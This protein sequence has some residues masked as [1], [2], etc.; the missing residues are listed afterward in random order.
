ME[1]RSKERSTKNKRPSS[2]MGENPESKLRQIGGLINNMHLS[3]A[4][5]ANLFHQNLLKSG[6]LNKSQSHNLR[7]K[8]NSSKVSSKSPCV[9]NLTNQITM[10]ENILDFNAKRSTIRSSNSNSNMRSTSKSSGAK[11]KNLE[12]LVKRLLQN[13]GPSFESVNHLTNKYAY[14]QDMFGKKQDS[15][16][17]QSQ[18]Q[19]KRE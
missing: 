16:L 8:Q 5:M 9:T 2:R 12:A 15:S 6:K 4:S 13:G 17:Q 7:N 3:N 10:L 11:N 18:K 14:F 19:E 1:P